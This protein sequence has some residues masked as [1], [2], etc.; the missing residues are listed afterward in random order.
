MAGDPATA[1][2]LVGMAAAAAADAFLGLPAVEYATDDALAR[3]VLGMSW[4]M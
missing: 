3:D 4:P 2:A 1:F